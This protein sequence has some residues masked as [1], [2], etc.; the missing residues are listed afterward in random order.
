MKQSAVDHNGRV[1][2]LVNQELTVTG[3]QLGQF[4]L[5]LCDG[6]RHAVLIADKNDFLRTLIHD[7]RAKRR[8]GSID[9]SPV[10]RRIL[11]E[12]RNDYG[13][14]FSTATVLANH[15]NEALEFHCG[16]VLRR[17]EL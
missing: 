10:A 3:Q 13:P 15:L 12:G 6:K 17:N 2:T 4:L 7:N 1:A 5:Q 8:A 16:L 11:L 9:F 14:F